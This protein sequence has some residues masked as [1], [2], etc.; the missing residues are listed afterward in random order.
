[1]LQRLIPLF[2]VLLSQF[3]WKL[4]L[5]LLDIGTKWVSDEAILPALLALVQGNAPAWRNEVITRYLHELLHN[6]G[7][8]WFLLPYVGV[9]LLLT[10]AAVLITAFTPS[11]SRRAA[12]WCSFG[13]IGAVVIYTVSLLYSYLFLFDPSEAL[14]LASVSRYLGTPITALLAVITAQLFTAAPTGTGRRWIWWSAAALICLQMFVPT[15]RYTAAGLRAAPLLAAQ[16][17]HDRYLAQHAAE[18]IRTVSDG[19]DVY[20][21][22]PQDNGAAITAAAYE[23]APAALPEQNSGI[24]CL[25]PEDMYGGYTVHC[26]PD[27][28]SEILYNGPFRYVYLYQVDGYFVTGYRSLFEDEDDLVNDSLLEILRQADGSVLLRRIN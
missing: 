25:Y 22:S 23:L 9:L 7:Y 13:L 19:S 8:G 12:V 18:V 4:H 3:T 27:E 24:G 5:L 11:G 15:C 6:A 20:F 16:T 26:T 14:S 1:M 10:A 28:W 21:I 2:L 17:Q